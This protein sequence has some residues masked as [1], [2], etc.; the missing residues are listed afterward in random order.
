M[1]F[2]REQ[3]LALRSHSRLSRGQSASPRSSRRKFRKEIQD[4]VT[5]TLVSK[6]YRE[7]IAEKKLRVVSLNDLSD[8]EFGEDRS[9]RFRATVVTAPDST[10]LNTRISQSSCLI[11]R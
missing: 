11:R 1:G 6:S 10:C 8:V 5:Q 4:E 9:I 3:L 2:G 7:A